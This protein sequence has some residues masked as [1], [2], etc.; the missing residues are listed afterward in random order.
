MQACPNHYFADEGVCYSCSQTCYTCINART[1]GC[2]SCYLG[3]QLWEGEC[4]QTCP[5]GTFLNISR[6]SY[7][8]SNCS[9]CITENFCT[10]CKAGRYMI[11]NTGLCVLPG[12]CPVSTYSED[13]SHICA[14]CNIACISCT[15]STNKDCLKPN[16]FG[17]Y[18]FT[19]HG[20][21]DRLICMQGY[22]LFIDEARESAC[23][24]SCHKTCESCRSS[25]KEHC[26]TCAKGY[27]MSS[28]SPTVQLCKTCEEIDPGLKESS[29]GYCFGKTSK[30]LF[31]IEICGDG[32]NLGQVG[33]DDGN[34]LDGDGCDSNC[35]IE[36][37]FKCTHGKD[38]KDLCISYIRPVA[39]LTVGLFNT[40]LISFS[41]PVKCQI[42][43][44][45]LI[46]IIFL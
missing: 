28:I 2:T 14:I 24:Q 46:N 42:D 17:G 45:N 30:Y 41:K 33:C 43:C 11:L 20:T 44:N 38:L 34:L 40:L 7:C 32:R 10:A 23:C 22:Y 36:Y 27:H 31:S 29:N 25:G 16:Y 1:G 13:K 19:Q 37:G 4:W 21:S 39:S 35:K 26:E 6:C 3:E 9:R 15:G 8:S 5:P 12:D 18:A